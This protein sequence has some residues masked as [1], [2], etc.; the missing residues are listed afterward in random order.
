AT[1]SMFNGAQSGQ[2]TTSF[3]PGNYYNG[4]VKSAVIAASGYKVLRLMIGSNDAANNVPLSSW[5][6]NMQ[7]IISDALTWPVDAIVVE[8]I[9]VRLDRGDATLDLIRQY[10]AA[11]SN[12]VTLS[13]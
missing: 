4:L 8:E 7:A 13:P 3:L 11:R 6:T 10:N 12:L 9:G 2:T 5:L 1:M